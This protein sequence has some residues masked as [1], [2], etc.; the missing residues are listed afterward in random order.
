[1]SLD[2]R[3]R[4]KAQALYGK[5][6]D[7]YPAK[8]GI[9]KGNMKL[10]KHMPNLSQPAVLTCPGATPYCQG[11][12]GSGNEKHPC[13]NDHSLHYPSV[14][15]NHVGNYKAS[16]LPDYKD[17]LLVQVKDATRKHKIFRFHPE[18]DFYSVKYIHDWIHVV[19]SCPDVTFFGFTRSWRVPNLLPHLDIL[20]ML[21]NVSLYAST[22]PTTIE[23]PP[24][25]NWAAMGVPEDTRFEECPH[26][27]GAV[28][29][30]ETCIRCAD[31]TIIPYF[32]LH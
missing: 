10:G 25:W 20:R 21:P 1:M 15:E 31:T 29:D 22:D 7:L 27:S 19:I 6:M 4:R 3:F 9:V 26:A 11:A 14:Q 28:A 30:C 17:D 18:G 24:D 32:P 23:G 13:Y 12:P 5:A 8:I 2:S 16:F